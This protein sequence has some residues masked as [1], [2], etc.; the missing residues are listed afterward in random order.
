MTSCSHCLVYFTFVRETV[1]TRTEEVSMHLCRQPKI[2]WGNLSFL[3]F[4]GLL[5]VTYC[6]FPHCSSLEMK[7]ILFTRD[8]LSHRCLRDREVSLKSYTCGVS[9]SIFHDQA[10]SKDANVYSRVHSSIMERRA[11]PI[12]FHV[13]SCPFLEAKWCGELFTII[14]P[15]ISAMPFC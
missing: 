6:L 12:S 2:C 14:V 7:I 1:V 13:L 15:Q 5:I 9:G 4:P 8:L 3:P 10:N 11:T